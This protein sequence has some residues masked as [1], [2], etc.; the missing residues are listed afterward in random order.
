MSLIV[1]LEDTDSEADFPEHPWDVQSTKSLQRLGNSACVSSQ[2]IE[3]DF[4]VNRTPF[5]LRVQ[6]ATGFRP[7]NFVPNLSPAAFTTKGFGICFSFSSGAHMSYSVTSLISALSVGMP[8]THL[9]SL[10]HLLLHHVATHR[11]F[12]QDRFD[13]C[14][15]VT[16]WLSVPQGNLL[17]LSVVANPLF[18]PSY[19]YGNSISKLI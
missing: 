14:L 11:L 13:L 18:F 3:D 8:S 5:E 16:T 2:Y 12:H 19:Y 17:R 6:A 1:D 15:H 10:S 4:D 9:A 7:D